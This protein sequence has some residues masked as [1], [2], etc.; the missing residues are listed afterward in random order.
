MQGQKEQQQQQHKLEMVDEGDV[1]VRVTSSSAT[2][3]RA[4]V[5]VTVDKRRWRISLADAWRRASC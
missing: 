3:H 1:F 2:I 5:V 4:A